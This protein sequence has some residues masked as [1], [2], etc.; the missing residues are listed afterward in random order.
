[1]K[2]YSS[3]FLGFIC[4]ILGITVMA[5]NGDEPDMYGTPMADYEVKGLV[6]DTEGTPI[7]G[8]HVKIGDTS[9]RFF[10]GWGMDKIYTDKEGKYKVEFSEFPTSRLYV[11]FSD[12]NGVYEGQID[13]KDIKFKGKADAWYKGRAEIEVNAKLSKITK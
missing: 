10:Q 9:T 11:S 1:M 12:E 4:S 2:Y 13:Y 7:E 5:C 6:T 8:I 3:R